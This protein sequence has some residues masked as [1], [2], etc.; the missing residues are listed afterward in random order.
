M[1][2]V[3]NECTENLPAGLFVIRGKDIFLL[4]EH[5]RKLLGSREEKISEEE[6]WDFV[7][8]KEAKEKILSGSSA[9]FRVGGGGRAE[10]VEYRGTVKDGKIFGCLIEVT[11]HVLFDKKMAAVEKVSREMKVASSRDELYSLAM[12]FTKD[13]LGYKNCAIL[14]REENCLKVV[15]ER[16]YDKKASLMEIPLDGK[17]V[18]VY[19]FNRNEARYVPDVLKAEEYI[20]G[21]PGA[22]CEYAVPIAFREEKYGVFDVQNDE[23][24]SITYSDRILFNTLVSEMATVL[25]GLQTLEKLKESEANYRILV[26]TAKEGIIKL[27][28]EENILFVN[29]SLSN[30]LGYKTEE[31]IGKNLRSFT[32]EEQFRIFTEKTELRR[33][34]VKD[35]YEAVFIHKNG[36]VLNTI[37]SAAPFY[38]PDGKFEGTFAIV[39][40]ITE[41]KE[42]EEKA[43]FYH[44][45]LRHDIG[46]KNQIIMGYLELLMETELD[47]EQK[48]LVEMAYSAITSSNELIKKVKEMQIATE[49]SEYFQVDLGGE[50]K[51]TIDEFSNEAEKKGMEIHYQPVK[52]VIEGNE[53]VREIFANIIGNAIAHSG[54][55][56]IYV[57]LKN[58]EKYVT[59]CVEDDGNGIPPH[60]KNKIFDKKVKGEESNGS[61][62][63][64]YLVKTI[65]E[66]YGGEIRMGQGRKGGTR[67]EIMLPRR[68][69]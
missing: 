10:W 44:S 54:G 25:K 58:D 14:E 18:T 27:D 31:I 15:R 62:L 17:G 11:S 47:E 16:G 12:D 63:G 4:N 36:K 1:S 53:V 2:D 6:F 32:T 61:G 42:A 68:R 43:E 23:I 60:I 34:G 21:V 41:I 13:V 38:S 46:N 28:T 67:F 56:N 26:E 35:S 57:D 5:M 59:I 48:E 8:S 9:R 39:T 22:R 37:V 29:Q 30:L 55:K 69:R 51:R 40:D 65:V 24:D 52:S 45:L 66:S 7:G 33:D 19:A 20:E 49:E 3:V 64:L 50:I